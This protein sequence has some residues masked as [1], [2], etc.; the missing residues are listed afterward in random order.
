MILLLI[1]WIVTWLV[2]VRIIQFCSNSTV[3]VTTSGWWFYKR[4]FFH[5]HGIIARYIMIRR[6]GWMVHVRRIVMRMIVIFFHRQDLVGYLD[7]RRITRGSMHH[8]RIATTGTATSTIRRTMT[9]PTAA[10]AIVIVGALYDPQQSTTTFDSC[11]ASGRCGYRSSCRTT[12]T[13]TTFGGHPYRCVGNGSS[14]DRGSCM[15]IPANH[16]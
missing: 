11:C 3:V 14:G 15:A 6:I 12:T 4:I 8:A 1:W 13:T 10:P 7:R 9:I 5:P 2:F 16:P